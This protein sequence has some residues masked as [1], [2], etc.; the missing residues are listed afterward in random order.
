MPM[1]STVTSKGQ[2]T[3]PKP[4]RDLLGIRPHD[5]VDF[6][7]RDGAVLLR[8]VRTFRDLRGRVPARGTGDFEAEREKAK[9]R[10]ASRVL[11]RP[12]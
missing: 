1:L 11:G 5:K 8:P 9:A 10:V 12:G 4:I 2:V 3:I 7:V 6:V